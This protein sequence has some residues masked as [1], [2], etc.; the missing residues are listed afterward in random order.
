MP[1]LLLKIPPDQGLRNHAESFPTNHDALL[2]Q[3][4]ADAE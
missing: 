2:E 3:P 1:D 4:F